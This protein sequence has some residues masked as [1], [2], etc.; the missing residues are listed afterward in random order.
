MVAAT[1]AAMRD[2]IDVIVQGGLCD[3]RGHWFGKPDIL[4]RV[5]TKSRFGRME[6]RE[7]TTLSSRVRPRPAPSSNSGS[8][9]IWWRECRE[10]SP[11]G[12]LVVGA[13]DRLGS[14]RTAP[15]RSLAR[16][17]RPWRP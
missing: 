17:D 14:A 6:L 5:N 2:G 15:G 3:G 4:R 1:I 9:P 13:E 10:S 12:S 11:H 8:T 7:S 16:S